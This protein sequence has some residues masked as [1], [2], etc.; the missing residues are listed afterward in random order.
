VVIYPV[1]Y[2]D[3][4]FAALLTCL[5]LLQMLQNSKVDLSYFY[6]DWF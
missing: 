1:C 3:I 6:S 2:G 5:H 4:T